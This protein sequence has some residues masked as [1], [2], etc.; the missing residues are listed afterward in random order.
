[1]ERGLRAARPKEFEKIHGE[2]DKIEFPNGPRINS[3][4][5]HVH[6]RFII[7]IDGARADQRADLPRCRAEIGKGYVARIR[8]AARD[9]EGF[10]RDV[11]PFR[12]CDLN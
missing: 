8:G 9:D 12:L 1:L 10:A 6:R 11:L 4:R 7:D 3:G 2:F 5:V